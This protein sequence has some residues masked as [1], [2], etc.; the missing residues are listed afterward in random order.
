MTRLR[1]WQAVQWADHLTQKV[2]RD[3]RID[4]RGIQPPVPKQNLDE[5]DVDLLFKQMR[6]KAVSLM[7]LKT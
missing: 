7:S 2:G 3:L 6:G 5:A 1:R 4:H